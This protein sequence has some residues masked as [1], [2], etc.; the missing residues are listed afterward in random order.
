M[1][2]AFVLINTEIDYEKNVHKEICKFDGVKDAFRCFGVYNII[3]ELKTQ[4]L[5]ELRKIV[6]EIQKID[7]VRSTLTMSSSKIL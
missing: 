5:K 3:A 2:L 4:T 1:V 7:K 6:V